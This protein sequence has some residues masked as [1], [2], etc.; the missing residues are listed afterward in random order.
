MRGI[1]RRGMVTTR[2]R[3]TARATA[4]R[5]ATAARRKTPALFVYGSL[6]HKKYWR[7]ALGTKAI[8]RIKLVAARAPGWRRWWS[9]VRRNYGG[10]VLNMK[11]ASGYAMWG[12]IVEGLSVEAW[13]RLDAQERSHLPRQRVLVVTAR[14]RRVAADCYRQR[15]R[16][17]EGRPAANYVAAVREG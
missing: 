7:R 16:R 10:A 15:G 1:D 3:V 12:A 6:L 11:P 13:A 14:G 9:G 17:A 2:K 4:A 5:S 8:A